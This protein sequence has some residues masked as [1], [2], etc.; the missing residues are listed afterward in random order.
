MKNT[1]TVEDNLRVWGK[2]Y[3]W[4][5]SGD[6]WSDSW[7]GPERQ[8]KALLEPRLSRFLPTGSLLEIAPGYGRW[9][10]FLADRC[11][12]L[13]VVDL[14]PNCIEY[15]RKRFANRK[16]ISYFVNDGRSLGMIPNHSIDFVFSFDS[17]VHADADTMH[18]YVRQL[19][20]KMKPR[21]HGFINHSNAAPYASILRFGEWMSSR[22]ISRISSLAVRKLGRN[23]RALDMSADS[24]AAFLREAGMSCTSQEIFSIAALA[25]PLDCVS[26][27]VNQPSDA[28]PI[29]KRIDLYAM[30]RKIG[31]KTEDEN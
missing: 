8:W 1:N 13:T 21:A 3:N 26:T 27:F 12:H 2:V 29:R 25:F 4:P 10:Q 28:M 16:N 6:E 9:T 22:K 11:D 23:W 7:G 19:A 17:L 24:M 14:A 30:L 20:R 31:S 15:C 18:E 5:K